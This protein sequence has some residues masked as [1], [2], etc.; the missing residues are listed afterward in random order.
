MRAPPACLG[1]SGL[2]AVSPPGKAKGRECITYPVLGEAKKAPLGNPRV[3]REELIRICSQAR[4]R[5]G[6]Q[7]R[8][9]P[10]V[11]VRVATPQEEPS[12][13]RNKEK[14]SHLTYLKTHIKGNRNV[15]QSVNCPQRNHP[16]QR[17]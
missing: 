2:Q 16:L 17:R 7:H 6:L 9:T 11:N 15:L 14:L 5:K 1:G 3:Q 13:P 10:A 12:D 8:E 4:R